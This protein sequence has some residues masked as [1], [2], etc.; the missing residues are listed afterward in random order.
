MKVSVQLLV[1]LIK[2][3]H[4]ITLIKV[5]ISTTVEDV[6]VVNVSGTFEYFENNYL[7]L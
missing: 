2:C 7:I 4:N 5:T 3:H 6:L 1:L